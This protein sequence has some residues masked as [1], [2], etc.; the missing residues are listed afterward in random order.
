MIFPWNIMRERTHSLP[1]MMAL[2][3]STVWRQIAGVS[4]LARLIHRVWSEAFGPANT[5]LGCGAISESL[6]L[7]HY[8]KRGLHYW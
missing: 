1:V 8:S 3:L 7:G 2:L 5:R 4:E 6:T